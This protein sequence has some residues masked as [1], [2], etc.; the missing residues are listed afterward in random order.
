MPIQNMTPEEILLATAEQIAAGAKGTD[1]ASKLPGE[2]SAEANAR[3]TQGYKDL[4][5]KPVLTPELQ[6]IGAEVKFVRQGAGGVGEYVIVTPFGAK[7]PADSA[8]QWGVGIIPANSK[9]ITGTTLGMFS[10]G[11]GT[12]TNVGEVPVTTITKAGETSTRSFEGQDAYYTAKVGTTGKTQAQLDAAKGQEQAL[13]FNKDIAA[14]LGG[15]VDP[16]TGKVANVAGK[17][18]A[19]VIPNA[20]GTTT[21]TA[22]DGTKTTVKTPASAPSSAPTAPT[23]SAPSSGGTPGSSAPGRSAAMVNQSGNASSN[24]FVPGS[25]AAKAWNEQRRN[26]YQ[27]A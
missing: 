10:M 11:D 13:Q 5:A 23:S 1:R 8:T 2:T 17:T 3:I 25:E 16:V 19:S 14:L 6:D 24:P 27:D 4:V 15:T 12:V 21:I 18:V 22:S 9:Y 7:I 26:H 20:D